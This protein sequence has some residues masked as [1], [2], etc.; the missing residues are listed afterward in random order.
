MKTITKTT[1]WSTVSAVLIGA[2]ISSF[3]VQ[4]QEEKDKKAPAVLVEVKQAATSMMAPEVYMPGTIVSKNDSRIAA[5]VSGLVEWVA[6]EGT[7]VKKGD[8]LAKID[9]SDFALQVAR[10]DS[11]VKRLQ[12]RIKFQSTELSRYQELAA[13]NNVAVSR[14]EEVDSNLTMT[15]Q[16]L[17]QARIGYRQAKLSLERT[18]V[19]APFPGRVVSRLS[20][21]GEYAGP[22]R[23]MVRLVDVA[24]LEVKAQAPVKLAMLLKDG[25]DVALKFGDTRVDTTI[26]SLIPVGDEISR[27]MEL[28]VEVPTDS[29]LVQGLIVGSAVQVA[30]PSSAPRQVVSVPR[31]ALVLRVDG[32]Y[33]FRIKEDKTAERL[34]V[35]T[36]ATKGTQVAIGDALLAGDNVVVRGG[37]RLRAGQEVRFK[38]TDIEAAGR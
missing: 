10:M 31:D 21:A 36:G 18:K 37:E 27:T 6:S 17:A 1:L 34:K 12:S 30:L 20:Q 5:Q 13:T 35:T 11:Q 29:D 26:R 3:S 9:D 32:T 33:V 15:K 25:Q 28:R 4:A 8:V 19:R 22:G 7:L 23:Q 38:R 14:L 2:T 16:D 24:H